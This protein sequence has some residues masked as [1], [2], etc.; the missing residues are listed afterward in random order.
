IS[1]TTSAVAVAVEQ[2]TLATNE[3]SSSTGNAFDGTVQV[4]GEVSEIEDFVKR[5]SVA[6]DDMLSVSTELVA[7]AEKVLSEVTNFLE[8]I[9]A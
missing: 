9:R 3:I 5:S 1:A 7:D 2:Q 6:A 4:K 8:K